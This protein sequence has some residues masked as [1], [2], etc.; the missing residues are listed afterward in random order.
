MPSHGNVSVLSPVE[1]CREIV[2]ILA[3]GVIRLH[4]HNRTHGFPP[5]SGPGPRNSLE[6]PGET[7]LSVSRTRGLRPRDD[8]DNA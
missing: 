4:R 2:S 5:D 8:G 6:L 1:R 3:R 7:R